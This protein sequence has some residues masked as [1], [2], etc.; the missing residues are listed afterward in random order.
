MNNRG[1]E[2]GSSTVS[3]AAAQKGISTGA[4][5]AL[6]K[7]LSR[8]RFVELAHHLSITKTTNGLVAQRLRGF[9]NVH[10]LE[11]LLDMFGL[12][13]HDIEMEPKVIDDLGPDEL[14]SLAAKAQSNWKAVV[15][16][17]L[18]S[19]LAEVVRLAA[20]MGSA[21]GIQ[22]LA[23]LLETPEGVEPNPEAP[24]PNSEWTLRHDQ[25]HDSPGDHLAPKTEL[26]KKQRKRKSQGYVVERNPRVDR[27]A[28]TL[29][30]S[31]LDALN[32]AQTP[33]GFAHELLSTLETL[34]VENLER[35]FALAA[36]EEGDIERA[37]ATGDKLTQ[38][39]VAA[40]VRSLA[41]VKPDAKWPS[42]IPDFDPGDTLG[43][44]IAGIAH[45]NKH[46]EK[47]LE[48]LDSVRE[49][50]AD[51]NPP[52]PA[53]R[54]H[55]AYIELGAK[56][57]SAAATELV[58]AAESGYKAHPNIAS[59]AYNRLEK[60][61]NLATRFLKTQLSSPISVNDVETLV[62]LAHEGDPV[63]VMVLI[64]DLENGPVHTPDRT[65]RILRNC[66]I[67]A[68]GMN[69]ESDRDE[70]IDLVDRFLATKATDD[71]IAEFLELLERDNTRV[72]SM[73]D[74]DEVLSRLIELCRRLGR[75]ADAVRHCEDL[76]R[77]ANTANLPYLDPRDVLDT[78]REFGEHD[79]ALSLESTLPAEHTQAAAEPQ[80][81]DRLYRIVFCGGDEHQARMAPEIRERIHAT[82]DKQVF[83]HFHHP[84]WGSN[85]M[86]SAE[87]VLSDLAQGDALVLMPLVRTNMGRFLRRKVGEMNRPWISCTGRGINSI[88]RAIDN[89][90]QVAS[91]LK[92]GTNA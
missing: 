13:L 63:A 19:N 36:L 38:L 74:R 14:S 75:T 30:R 77:L 76:F 3:L 45:V 5:T 23:M 44:A 89:A 8:Q 84:G 25:N 50:T 18:G 22:K 60:F 72:R 85:W 64:D 17:L 24:V 87:E 15:V 92:K 48:L 58:N 88:V 21:G 70:V 83:V 33:L 6:R 35:L 10:E 27:R 11:P 52:W 91:Q 90:V 57:T 81:L 40:D 80:Q 2:A 28:E 43:R 54:F 32:P 51:P 68:L 7:A 12:A 71:Q 59:I 65:W 56:N 67:G 26:G 1:G 41:D 62:Q 79:L 47:A 66:L 42:K 20:A 37:T 31:I 49:L 86:D 53:A 34:G 61:G 29:G 73:Y 78:I 69:S 55:L 4:V 39:L 46:P 82:Y 9:Q 16:D